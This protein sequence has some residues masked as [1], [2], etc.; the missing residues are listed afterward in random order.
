LPFDDMNG[1]QAPDFVRR[2]AI[3]LVVS[4]SASQIFKRPILEAPRIGCINLHNA[5]LPHYRG[6]LPNFW[7]MYHG[8][9]ESVL[10]IHEMVEDL[11]K[12]DILTQAGTTIEPDDSLDEV[13]RRTKHRSAEVLAETLEEVRTATAR[14]SPLPAVEGSYF[15][16]PTREQAREFRRRGKRLL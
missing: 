13:I 1:E 4:V 2:E 16:W 5:P 10:T 14:L 8:E 15:T 7:Q 11:D 6:M 9:D 3:D 12:G